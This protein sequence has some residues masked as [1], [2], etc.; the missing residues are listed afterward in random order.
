MNMAVHTVGSE[1]NIRDA[2]EIKVGQ[3]EADIIA[4]VAEGAPAD[5]LLGEIKVGQIEAGIIAYVVEGAPADLLQGVP[6]LCNTVLASKN[7]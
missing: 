6:I 7:C 5:L 1:M 4:Y 2:I 3:I